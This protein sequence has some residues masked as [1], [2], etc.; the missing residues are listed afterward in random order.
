MNLPRTPSADPTLLAKRDVDRLPPGLFEWRIAEVAAIA[1]ARRSRK[2]SE[3]P[4]ARWQDDIIAREILPGSRVLDL[5]CGNGLLL[6]RL[7][8]DREVRGQGV[9]WDPEAVLAATERGVSVLQ[10]DLSQGLGWFPDASFDVVVLE[11][12]LQTLPDPWLILGEMLRVGRRG[13]VSFPNF[14]HWRVIVDLVAHGRMPVTE[15]LPHHWYDSDNIHPFTLQ[16]FLDWVEA[17]NARVVSGHSFTEGTV[18]P[19]AAE[20]NLLAEAVLAVVER[21]AAPADPSA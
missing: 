2:P 13:I 3:P 10:A 8:R 17:T 16:D 5:G 18:R 9:E 20:D 15:R 6:A 1:G 11:E 12:T 14:A 7:Q 4:P 21:K 19:L